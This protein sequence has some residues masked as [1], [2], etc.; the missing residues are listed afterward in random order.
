MN[1]LKTTLL[2]VDENHVKNIVFDNEHY[3]GI[4]STEV[5]FE[6]GGT[7]SLFCI[8][9]HPSGWEMDTNYGQ[10]QGTGIEYTA[11]TGSWLTADKNENNITLTAMDNT[12]TTART[13]KVHIR[14]GNLA[15]VINVT[16]EEGLLYV[17]RFGGALKRTGN[18]WQFPTKVY[19]QAKDQSSGLR[20][21]PKNDDT[22]ADSYWDGKG[23][24]LALY[25]LSSTNYPAAKACF[26]KNSGYASITEKDVVWYLPAQN[27][28]QAAWVS[29]NS[30][31]GAYK[32]S[33]VYSWSSTEY[34]S[35]SS[36]AWIVSIGSGSISDYSNGFTNSHE[37]DSS[38]RLRC[39]REV[40]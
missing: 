28:L 30:F 5:F 24:T 35:Y 3:L 17:G 9:N 15:G 32:P 33:S 14:A 4:E 10:G 40:N 22:A 25:Q 6:W 7:A 38:N 31:D 19:I 29:N 27:Q 21:G 1:N 39:V 34:S 37:K 8:T 16:Q 12:V 18:E 36:S 26:E 23:N 2:V 11:G 13:A 20:W